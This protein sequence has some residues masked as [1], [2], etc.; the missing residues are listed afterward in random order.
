MN[1][2]NMAILMDAIA[3][4]GPFPDLG[5]NMNTPLAHRGEK[6]WL[7]DM[8]G[9]N[10]ISVSCLGGWAS[11]LS[12]QEPWL[13]P[14]KWAREAKEWLD[15]DNH[16]AHRLFYPN[17]AIVSIISVKQAAEVLDYLSVTNEV[18]WMRVLE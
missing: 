5:F 1:E 10:C 14:A 4:G 13:H 16:Q 3:T 7:H 9:R 12:R 11:M 2:Q 18:N 17:A 6:P 8:S 15:L